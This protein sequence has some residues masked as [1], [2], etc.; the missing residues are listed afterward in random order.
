MDWSSAPSIEDAPP[1]PARR[2]FSVPAIRPIFEDIEAFLERE[3]GQLPL[4]SVACFGAG[5]A[6]WFALPARL[7]WAG[8][9]ALAGGVGSAGV[10]APAGSRL[11]RALWLGGLALALGCGWIW[12]RA[13]PCGQLVERNDVVTGC[14]RGL[15]G[16]TDVAP[17]RKEI[18]P[19]DKIL[20]V[21][22]VVTRLPHQVEQPD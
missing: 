11:R 5:I 22:A 13:D 8:F 2:P 6:A 21:M 9:V 19:R 20:P 7:A 17:E 15:Q 10:L 3:R 16:R 12:L 14:W 4:W 18:Q 1:E